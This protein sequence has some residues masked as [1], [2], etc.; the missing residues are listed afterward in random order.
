MVLFQFSDCCCTSLSAVLSML[1][2]GRQSIAIANWCIFP[3]QEFAYNNKHTQQTNTANFFAVT[4]LDYVWKQFAITFELYYY[5]PLY[6][7]IPA[8]KFA[9]S[10]W[11]MTIQLFFKLILKREVHQVSCFVRFVNSDLLNCIYV[12]DDVLAF[13][14]TRCRWWTVCLPL[15]LTSSVNAVPSYLGRDW[16]ANE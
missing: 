10:S 8:S 12:W 1:T 13:S 4:K 15:P 6:T 7:T 11:L 3:C 2:R 9:I 14:T 5:R 16:T